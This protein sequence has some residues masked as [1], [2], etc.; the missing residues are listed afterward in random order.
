MHKK[1]LN[2]SKAPIHCF[3]KMATFT[4]I[5]INLNSNT[6]VSKDISVSMG[7]KMKMIAN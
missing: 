2:N 7:P 3:L 4:G 5:K 6:T 1:P